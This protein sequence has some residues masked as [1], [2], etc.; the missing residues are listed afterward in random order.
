MPKVRYKP[1]KFRADARER[2]EQ[3]NEI[4]EEYRAQGYVL[5]LRQLYYQ[6][7][8]RDLIANEQREYKR[9]GDLVNRA[10][11][12]G[13]I[14]WEAIE[15]RTRNIESLPH[16]E[17][18]ADAVGAVAAHYR[19]DKWGDQAVRIEVWVEKEALAGVFTGVCEELQVPWFACRGYVSQSEQWSAGQRFARI[20]WSGQRPIV[21]HFGDHD[22]SGIDMTRDNAK[23]LTLFAEYGV[24]VRRLALNMDQVVEHQPPPN[25]AKATDTRFREYAQAHGEESWELDALPPDVLTGL[26]RDAVIDLR[27]GERWQESE[28]REQDARGRLEA[29]AADMAT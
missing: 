28:A 13:L 10:R 4:I 17:S 29:V 9:L 16:W 11:L 1:R 2:I 5:T 21:L 19:E 26:V 25:P 18:P 15:D 27:D 14:D 20:N 12:A 8:A 22:P 7:V 6:F 23:R 24:E 3:A